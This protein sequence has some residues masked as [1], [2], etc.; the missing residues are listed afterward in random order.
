MSLEKLRAK[1]AAAYEPWN[2]NEKLNPRP[3][4]LMDILRALLDEHEANQDTADD[5]G[6]GWDRAYSEAEELIQR[7]GES[8]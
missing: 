2:E 1:I 3:N 5:E 6:E 8:E 7:Y 4:A